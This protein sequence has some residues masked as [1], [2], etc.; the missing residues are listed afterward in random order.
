VGGSVIAAVRRRFRAEAS[1]SQSPIPM[2]V[3]R[4]L[5]SCALAVAAMLLV[6]CGHTKKKPM[7]D[8]KGNFINPYPE[9]TYEHF[10]VD[11][12]YPKTYDTWKNQELLEKT[13]AGN[14]RLVI[15]LKKQRGL[16][17]NGD[18]VVIDYPICSGRSTHPTPPG[19]YKVLEKVVDKKSNKYGRIYDADGGLVHGDA[20]ITQDAVPEGGRFQGASMSYWMRLTNDGIGHH[21][22]PVKRYPASHACIRGPSK[23]MPVVFGKVAVGTPVLVVEDFTPEHAPGLVEIEASRSQAAAAH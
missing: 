5:S 9:G 18:A 13:N 22:G 8:S 16:L 1:Q 19:E 6:A 14:S 21:I 17:L 20:D 2:N 7:Y 11:P 10:T 3:P 15:C 4:L 12:K 23:V